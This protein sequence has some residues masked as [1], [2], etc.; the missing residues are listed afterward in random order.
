MARIRV[1]IVDDAVVIRR[2]LH[3]ILSI[4]PALEV[5]GSAPGGKIALARIPQLNPDVIILD[6]EMAEMDG[7]QTLREIRKIYPRLP[8]I[9]FSAHTAKGA[10]AT[11]DALLLGATDYVTKPS[12]ADSLDAAIESVR[13][14]LLPK[15]KQFQPL[16]KQ[17]TL[18]KSPISV[19]APEKKTLVR[20][21]GRI[22]VVAIGVSTGGPNALAVVLQKIPRDFP[23]PVLLV[24]HMPPLFTKTFAERLDSLCA[25]E[26]KEA[27]GGEF[28]KPGCAWLAPGDFHLTLKKAPDGISLKLNQDTPENFCRPSVDTTFRSAA[29]IYQGH[30]LGVVM[31]GMGRDGLRGS[32]CI[33]ELGGQVIVQ[34]KESSVVWS[35]PQAVVNAGLAD[36]IVKLDNLGEEIVNRVKKSQLSS[37]VPFGA[38]HD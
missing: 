38:T 28:L 2:L 24:Q 35:M 10:A 12:N 14:N 7:L 26:V 1:L 21:S 34:D 33:Y 9:M 8:V 29:E 25:I 30:C 31:T 22:D 5:V 19:S 11:I 15:I 17:S 37:A 13:E 18:E 4:D 16:I 27:K 20:K 23:V 32:E 3:N 36:Q 6:V